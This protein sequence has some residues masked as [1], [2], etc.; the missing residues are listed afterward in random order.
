MWFIS[1]Q[2]AAA[3]RGEAAPLGSILDSAM[4]PPRKRL[5][6]RVD[7]GASVLGEP[8]LKVRCRPAS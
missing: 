6:A 1:A 4:V 8:R 5:A 3:R 7:G 2:M